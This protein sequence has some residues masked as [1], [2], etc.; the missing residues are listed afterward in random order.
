MSKKSCFGRLFDKQHV[1]RAHTLVKSEREHLYQIYWSLWREMCWKK[2]VV[3]L[4]KIVRLFVKAFTPDDKYS[5]L[6]GDN[7]TEPIHMQL[8]QKQKK[9]FFFIFEIYINFGTFSKNIWT[10]YVMYFGNYGL[11]KT[12]LHNCLKKSISEHPSRSN[13]VNRP[14]HFGNLN[15]SVVSIFI[16]QCEANWDKKGLS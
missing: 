14:K 3:V 5:L 8:S 13:M 4:L 10:S 2:S 9:I 7:L 6:T 11:Q 16:D 1:K 12:W 15:D